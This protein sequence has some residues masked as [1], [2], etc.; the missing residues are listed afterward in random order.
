LP[1]LKLSRTDTLGLQIAPGFEVEAA[2]VVEVTGQG[3]VLKGR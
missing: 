3:K 2:S 1:G